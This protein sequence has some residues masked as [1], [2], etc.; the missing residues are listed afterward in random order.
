MGNIKKWKKQ[1][2]CKKKQKKPGKSFLLR[3]IDEDDF[4]KQTS[5]AKLYNIEISWFG[6]NILCMKW[7]N[8]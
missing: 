7:V 5:F 2:L 1:L 6:K 4:A 3:T 8:L